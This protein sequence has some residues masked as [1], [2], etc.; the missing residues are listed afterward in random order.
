MQYT[1]T[2]L[3]DVL[4]SS[5][6]IRSAEIDEDTSVDTVEAWDSLK[7]LNLIL[8]LEAAFDV[9]FTEEQTVEMLNY[10]LIK[11]IMAE[12]HVQFAE[13]ATAAS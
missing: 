6:G 2:Q 3:K 11:L 10:P 8:A 9:T 13:T 5:L 12:H 7:H 4:A 1:E